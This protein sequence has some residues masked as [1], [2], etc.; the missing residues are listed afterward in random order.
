MLIKK[1]INKKP[2]LKLGFIGGGLSSTIGEAHYVASHLDGRW[3]LKSGFFSRNK[4]INYKTGKNWN[5]ASDRIHHSLDKF[6]SKEANKLDAVVI[7]TPTP[8]HFKTILNLTKKKI[9]IICEKPLVDSLEQAKLIQKI[10]KKTNGFLTVTYNY[11][12]YPMVRELRQLVLNGKLGKIKQ[13]HFEM[14]QAG[15]MKSNS[16]PQK[17]RL[18]DAKIPVI[19]LDLG[20][21]LHNLAYFII[22]KEPNR[23]MANYFNNS[24]HKKI[25]DNVLLWLE[26]K[27]GIKGSFWM[28]KTAIGNR[29]SL[30]LRIFGDKGS[31]EWIQNNSEEL[32]IAFK[33]GTRKIIDRASKSLI[34]HKKRYNRYKAGHPAGFME[35]FANLYFDIADHLNNFK[36]KTKNKN[37]YVFDIEHSLRGLDLFSSSSKSN[38][39]LSWQTINYSTKE[40]SLK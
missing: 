21:H 38:K 35:A 6:I 20:V 37:L 1:K 2:P 28:S 34:T 32:N 33:D 36:S 13:F 12:G 19:C 22:G 14:P 4:T 26:Y 30:K 7:L 24:K 27:S 9:P 25:I 16:K 8:N 10:I 15:F 31:A 40:S 17:W 23:V 18:K 11:T 5:I 29:N 39:N 3:E